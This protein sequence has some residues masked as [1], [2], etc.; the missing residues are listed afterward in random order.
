MVNNLPNSPESARAYVNNLNAQGKRLDDSLRNADDVIRKA[1]EA[2]QHRLN[3]IRQA[4]A[5]KRAQ[6]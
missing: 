5:A 4:E 2:E 1:A 6:K 3:V